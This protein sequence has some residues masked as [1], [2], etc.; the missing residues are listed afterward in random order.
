MVIRENSLIVTSSE[1]SVFESEAHPNTNNLKGSKEGLSIYAHSLCGRALLK[2]WMKT[3]LTNIQHLN[4]RF[5]DIE[6][7]IKYLDTPL[8]AEAQQNLN[9]SKDMGSV[10]RLLQIRTHFLDWICL[11]LF[12]NKF[13]NFSVV[14]ALLKRISIFQKMPPESFEA[15]KSLEDMIDRKLSFLNDTGDMAVHIKSG[16]DEVSLDSMR[17]LYSNL[18]DLLSKAATS[19]KSTIKS[20]ISGLVIVYYPQLGYLIALA[21]P[22]CQ[23]ASEDPLLADWEFKFETDEAYYFKNDMMRG[24]ISAKTD[25]KISTWKWETCSALLKVL[26]LNS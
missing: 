13:N 3:P 15:L 8:L 14:I 11:K 1:L 16:N 22:S 12:L 18:E 10:L 26:C 25:V 24:K 21:K 6:F 2:E 17:E 9:Q 5:K 20:H 19:I 4:L 23:F 7:L